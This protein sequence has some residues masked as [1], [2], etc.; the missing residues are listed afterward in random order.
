MSAINKQQRKTKN[1]RRF[2]LIES[3]EK[4]KKKKKLS[5]LFPAEMTRKKKNVPLLQIIRSV[6]GLFVFF[7]LFFLACNLYLS[8]CLCMCF[9]KMVLTKSMSIVGKRRKLVVRQ[10]IDKSLIE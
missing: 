9:S 6:S 2:L 8:L 7:S 1:G 10:R 3:S 4:S 5:T